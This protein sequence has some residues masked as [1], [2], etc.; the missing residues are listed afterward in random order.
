MPRDIAPLTN[1]L[2]ETAPGNQTDVYTLL[3]AWDKSV[4]AALERGG[5]S[6]YREVTKEHRPR[7]I[8]LVD[9]ATTDE[10]GETDWTS[11]QECTDAYPP[12]VD[13]HHCSQVLASV[14]A[15]YV[16][17]TRINQG[18][19]AIPEWTVDYLMEITM[20]ADTEW[21]WESAAAVGWAVGHSDAAVLDQVVDR[22]D[23]ESEPWAMGILEHVAFADPD[24]GITLLERLLDS[25]DT[26]EDLTFL[27][28]LERL[29]KQDLPNFPQYWEPQTELEYSVS[30]TEDQLDRLL[31]VLGAAVHPK[32]LAKFDDQ[33][34]FDL[35]RAADEYGSDDNG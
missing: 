5:G 22:T 27:R 23:T 25:P 13:D 4:E 28:S 30:F 33:F 18:P 8:D 17:R 35:Q 10:S 11:L 26:R 1:A 2:E 15:R 19:D 31:E 21:A 29:L 6:R 20:D 7:V 24:A 34:E 32:R 16:I 9:T 12:G 14:V 3:A